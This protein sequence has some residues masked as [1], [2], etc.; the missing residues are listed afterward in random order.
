MADSVLSSA[1]DRIERSDQP[2][3]E[4]STVD[5]VSHIHEVWPAF[6][7]LVGLKGRKMFAKVDGV[8]NSYTV[9]TPLRSTDPAGRFGLQLGV[10]AGGSYLRGRIVGEPPGAYDRIAPGMQELES[11]ADVDSSRPLVEFYRRHD[12]VELW[13][14]IR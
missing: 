8:T 11:L 5:D 4:R 14:P 13:I 6:E 12:H 3:M 1:P 10:L 2:V 9:C 7:A